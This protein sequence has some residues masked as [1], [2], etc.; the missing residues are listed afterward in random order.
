MKVKD[1]KACNGC[2]FQVAFP[3]NELVAPKWG[4]GNLLC[5]GEAPGAEEAARGEPFVGAAGIWLRGPHLAGGKRGGGLLAKAGITEAEVTFVNV[6][7]CRPPNNVFPLDPAARYLP[8]DQRH[9]AVQHCIQAHLKPVLMARKWDIIYA[10]GNHAF[11]VLT[12]STLGITEARGFIFDCR[13]Q[14]GTRVAALLHPAAVMRD[15]TQ[16]PVFVNDLRKAR[17]PA[18]RERRVTKPTPVQARGLL[19]D[20]TV[21]CVDVETDSAGAITHVGLSPAPGDAVVLPYTPQFVPIIREALRNARVLIGHNLL[22]FDWP[23]LQREFGLDMWQYEFWDTMLMH[24]LR[25]P[26]L[27]HDLAFCVSSYLVTTPWKHTMEADIETYCAADAART[28]ALYTV[29]YAELRDTGQ[30]LRVYREVSVPLA[31]LCQQMSE[32]GIYADPRRADVVRRHLEVRRN[33]LAAQLPEKLRPYLKQRRRRVKEN[34]RY[35][36]EPVSERV[37]PYRSA[38]LLSKYLYEDLGLPQQHSLA[39]GRVTVDKTAITRLQAHAKTDEQ[40]RVL[41]VL[42]ELRS[43]EQQ[44]ATFLQQDRLGWQHPRFHVHGTATG[45]LSSSDPNL[46]NIPAVVRKMYVPRPGHVFIEVDFRSLENRLTAWFAKDFDRLKRMEDP[47]FNEHRW[48][49]SLVFGIPYELVQKDKHRDSPYAK[50]KIV[51]HGTNY[52]MGARKISATHGI[53]YAEVKRI[54]DTVRRVLP[55]TFIWQSDTVDKARSRGWLETP[56][57]R[58]RWFW[59]DSLATQACAFLP[60]STGADVCF[61]TMIRLLW[62]RTPVTEAEA[63]ARW[64]DDIEPLPPEVKLVVQVH[65]SLLFECPAEMADRVLARIVHVAEQPR[66][67]L[68]GLVLPVDATILRTSWGD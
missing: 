20:A 30:L 18:L 51:V 29:L 27:P 59:T 38:K 19:K 36:L 37:V 14:P 47:N 57:G 43:I 34:G 56:Y 40:R 35:R 11:H 66:A 48:M 28:H 42:S 13:Q 55:K 15:Q 63:R 39:T 16:V 4:P 5:V 41:E 58:R 1:C 62:N 68:D 10:L 52:L 3:H 44:L 31:F 8:E 24:H 53:P 7:Q 26:D 54:L 12:D 46:Q 9:R 21:L 49:A 50:A 64:G 6:I 17:E 33:E 2:P 61:E 23:L 45:R 22:G 32:H 67:A 60:Q 65:D 25:N